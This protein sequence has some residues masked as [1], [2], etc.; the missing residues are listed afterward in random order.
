MLFRLQQ[1][2][3]EPA[4]L[5][6]FHPVCVA[7]FLLVSSFLPVLSDAFRTGNL[8]VPIGCPFRN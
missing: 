3:A 5:D 1:V 7:F 8:V 4:Q 6:F 2:Q